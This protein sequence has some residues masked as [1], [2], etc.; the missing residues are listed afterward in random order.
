M[1][2]NLDFPLIVATHRNISKLKKLGT[3]M[4]AATIHNVDHDF[5]HLTNELYV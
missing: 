2:T 1:N 5:C 3:W 4:L